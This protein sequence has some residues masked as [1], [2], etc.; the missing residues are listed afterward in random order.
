MTRT[1]LFSG[2]GEAYRELPANPS[3]LQDFHLLL[4]ASL[5]SQAACVVFIQF[6]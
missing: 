6:N 5:S 3:F 1:I 4:S 2:E